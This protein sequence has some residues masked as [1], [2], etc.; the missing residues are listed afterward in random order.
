MSIGASGI[1]AVLLAFFMER[2]NNILSEKKNRE[3]ERN[4]IINEYKTFKI[5]LGTDIYAFNLLTTAAQ[6]RFDVKISHDTLN[7]NFEFGDLNGMFVNKI[8]FEFGFTDMP[9]NV[10]LTMHKSLLDKVEKMLNNVDFNYYLSL[11][12]TLTDLYAQLCE[13]NFIEHLSVYGKD[14]REEVSAFLNKDKITHE[15]YINYPVSTIF[16]PVIKLKSYL[17]NIKK[18]VLEIQTQIINIENNH[19]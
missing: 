7:D 18:A 6:K 8:G 5:R 1:S 4:K 9:L 3:K 10:Y 13:V 12:A 11:E 16:D 19:E 14:M 17:N 15:I 2:N